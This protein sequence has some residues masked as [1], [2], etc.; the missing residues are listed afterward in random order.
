MLL[1]IDYNDREDFVFEKKTFEKVFGT[2]AKINKK[3]LDK[4]NF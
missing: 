4:E 2:P 3:H 1:T